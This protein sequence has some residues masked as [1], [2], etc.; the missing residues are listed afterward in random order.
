MSDEP[1]ATEAAEATEATEAPTQ[2]DDG[3]LLSDA[4]P[5]KESA[6]DDGWSLADGING[7]GDQPEWFKA[8]K[9]KTVADQAKAYSELEKKVGETAPEDYAVGL[10]ETI[11]PNALDGDMTFEWFKA[12]AKE[13]N[14]SQDAF[15]QMLGGYLENQAKEMNHD[16][17]AEMQALGPQADNRLKT[18]ATWGRGNLNAE[19]WEVFKGVASSAVGVEFLESMVGK[20][21]EAPLARAATP[22]E[23]SNTPDDLRKMRYEKTEHGQLRMAVDPEHKKRVEAAYREHYGDQPADPVVTQ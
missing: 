7:E 1:Q 3:S 2:T 6:S 13:A 21:R 19:H 18:L 8:D 15:N 23:N 11:D 5:T 14:L 17:S 20:S 4:T 22:A 10:P 16:R 12:A 9:Y